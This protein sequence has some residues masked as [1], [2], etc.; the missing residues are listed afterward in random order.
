MACSHIQEP[1]KEQSWKF[2]APTPRPRRVLGSG[3]Q[4]ALSSCFPSL[5]PVQTLLSFQAGSEK[6]LTSLASDGN[7]YLW[8]VGL[9][10]REGCGRRD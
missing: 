2:G 9:W 1:Q 3:P 5:P 6:L 8:V 4:G 7:V 10:G